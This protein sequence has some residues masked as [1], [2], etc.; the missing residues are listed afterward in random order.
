MRLATGGLSRIQTE[1][2]G[3]QMLIKRLERSPD[4]P[5]RKAS[6]IFEYFTKWERGLSNEIAQLSRV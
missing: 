3:T 6:E 5:E 4:S 1:H 2:L